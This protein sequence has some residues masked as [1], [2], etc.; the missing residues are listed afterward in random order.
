MAM[1]LQEISDRM[2]IQDLMVS[3][4]YAIDSR[5]CDALDDVFTPD[6]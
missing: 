3:H 2:E 6:A 5:D 4:S 1:S